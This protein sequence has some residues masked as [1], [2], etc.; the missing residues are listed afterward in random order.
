EIYI[1]NKIS[2]TDS[3][4]SVL[5]RFEYAD[6]AYR[7][8]DSLALI[9]SYHYAPAFG[10]LDGDG[11]VDM[12]L[13]TWNDGVAWYRN[14]G[15]DTGSRL[16]LVAERFVEL[17]R[18][19]HTTPAL[20]DIDDDGD[21]DLFVGETSRTINFYENVGSPSEPAFELVSD[22][23]LGIDVGKRSVPSFINLHGDGHQDMMI[24]SERE[25]LVWF[26]N[27]GARSDPDFESEGPLRVDVPHVA[28]PE[29]ADRDGDERVEMLVGA[30]GGG[31]IFFDDEP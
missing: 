16:E 5:V 2:A 9:P 8:R 11:L 12:V 13:G 23:Y 10:D 25:R 28:V 17:T 24:G 21:L 6:G 31:L 30:V 19:S 26:R 22:E 20:V 3:R 15:T 1:A 7:L 14:T 27:V 29:N 4:T 18:G